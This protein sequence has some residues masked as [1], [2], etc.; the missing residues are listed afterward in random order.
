[1]LVLSGKGGVGKSTVAVN[2][3]IALQREGFRVGLL[4]VDVHGP[5]VPTLLGLEGEQVLS[6]GEAFLPVEHGGLKVMSVGFLLRRREDPVIWRG[7]LK[8]GVIRQFLQE[9]EWGDLDFLIV[10]APP[11][12]GDEPLSVCQLVGEADGAVVVTTPQEVALSAVR[13]CISFCRKLEL[14][15][16]GVIE[17]MSGFLCPHCGQ[18]TDIFLADGG[19][20]MAEEMSVPFLGCIPLERGVALSGDGGTPFSESAV[21]PETIRAFKAIVGKILDEEPAAVKSSPAEGVSMRIAI[22]LADG[23][24]SMHFGHCER[25]VL[26]DVDTATKSIQAREELAAPAHEPGLLPRWL[27]ERGAQLIIA[28][29][30]GSRA[31]GLFTQNGIR[32]VVGA[33]AESPDALVAAYLDGTL[34]SGENVCDH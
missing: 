2:L 21:S 23:K 22:P 13:K 9:V 29:G 3:A 6:E 11:G 34:S 8:M 10:D 31:Q 25:F 26:L 16:L 4:D 30:M 12:T 15:V 28:G 33:P 20:R 1:V 27:A 7:P 19:R 18:R 14:R 5:S 24:L 32:V 17:N